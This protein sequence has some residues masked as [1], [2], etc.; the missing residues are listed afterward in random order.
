MSERRT[1]NRREFLR[2]KA[3]AKA[4]A[5]MLDAG[6]GEASGTREGGEP[7]LIQLSRPAMAC[8][9][10]I[11]LNAGQYPD[12]PQAALEALDLVERLEDQLTVYR[13]T[14]EV[15]HV[16]RY[17]AG[18]PIAVEPRLFALL[19]L[20][21]KLS[22]E[23][24]GAFDITT[25]P[26]TKVW[27]FYRRAGA[28]PTVD[29]IDEALAAVGAGHLI[30]DA[31]QGTIHFARSGVELNLGAIGKGYALD[32]AAE[33]LGAA[34]VGDFL[35]HGGQSSVLARGSQAPRASGGWSVGVGD[36]LR[37]AVRL[38]EVYLRDRALATSGASQQFFRH[39]GKRYG[40]IL[41]PRTGR[42]AEGVFSATVVAPAAAEADA[43]ST[44][45]YTLGVDGAVA[46]CQDHPRIG[47]LLVHPREDGSSVEIT[48]AGLAEDDWRRLP[49][50]G[51][52]G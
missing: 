50:A 12:G 32:R 47:M 10:E 51:S 35:L 3:A 9:F 5:G 49:P 41:D 19:A 21:V 44:A 23:T 11:F 48:T 17:A 20:A 46:Y 7:Y 4:A 26:L 29:A 15:M 40:H 6:T 52:A 38:A 34:G 1:S 18:E 2:G 22:Q 42:P 43:L 8:R 24:A 31:E 25:G 36:P 16:N 13:D 30:L 33:L 28:V 14:S 39:A 37:P 27:G 45:F